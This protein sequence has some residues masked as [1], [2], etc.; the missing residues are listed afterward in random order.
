MKVRGTIITI[1]AWL[2]LIQSAGHIVERAE[3]T[4]DPRDKNDAEHRI[5]HLEQ[6]G[7]WQIK[8]SNIV[9]PCHGNTAYFKF[10]FC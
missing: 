8:V 3:D 10:S 9:V 5:A 7:G 4:R 2:A 1:F 6:V